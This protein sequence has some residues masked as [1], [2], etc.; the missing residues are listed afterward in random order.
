[1]RGGE[2]RSGVIISLDDSL[3]FE[4]IIPGNKSV[5]DVTDCESV[6]VFSAEQWFRTILLIMLRQRKLNKSFYVAKTD[7]DIHTVN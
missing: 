3:V 4:I 1:M 5:F 7:S 6:R 2:S